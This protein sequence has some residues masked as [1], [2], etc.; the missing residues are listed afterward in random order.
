MGLV[1]DLYPGGQ[2]LCRSLKCRSDHKS[3]DVVV[4]HTSPI[5]MGSTITCIGPNI[6][7]PYIIL[8]ARHKLR[9]LDLLSLTIS[10]HL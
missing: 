6:V 5:R 4:I 8:L 7:D 10:A 9:L 2:K 1:E 3:L